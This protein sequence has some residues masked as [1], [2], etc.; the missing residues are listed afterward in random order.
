MKRGVFHKAWKTLQ[1]V[2]A[3]TLFK[4]PGYKEWW[5]RHR[6]GKCLECGRCCAKC[7]YLDWETGRCSVYPIRLEFRA[8]CNTRFPETFLQ[9]KG[10]LGLL[11]RECGYEWV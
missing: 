3:K 2:E 5:T 6:K 10:N 8:D 1:W 4:S 9:H 11:T 7:A